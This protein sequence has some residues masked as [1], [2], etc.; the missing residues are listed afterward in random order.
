MLRKVINELFINIIV[1]D[2]MLHNKLLILS[3]LNSILLIYYIKIKDLILSLYY[4]ILILYIHLQNHIFIKFIPCVFYHFEWWC[5]NIYYF[6][7]GHL[8]ILKINQTS[9][10]F[11]IWSMIFIFFFNWRKIKVLSLKLLQSRKI[12]QIMLLHIHL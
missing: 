1:Y 12:F 9:I 6:R 3:Q 8:K 10:Y 5:Q 7:I 11:F 4:F 2:Y